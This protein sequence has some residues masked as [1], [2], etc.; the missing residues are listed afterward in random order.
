MKKALIIDDHFVVRIG[1]QFVLEGLFPHI[2]VLEAES[3]PDG[4]QI[5]K[6]HKIDIVILD[7]NI[8]GGE[9]TKMISQIKNTL[10]NCK[11]LIFSD[12][13]EDKYALRYLQA[14]ANGFLSKKSTHKEYLD[15]ISTI[16]NGDKFVSY[17]IQQNILTHIYNRRPT[18][19]I[20]SWK[21]LSSRETEITKLLIQGMWTK[22]IAYKLKLKESTISTFK[23][24]IFDKIGVSNTLELAKKLESELD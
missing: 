3:F 7:I 23:R 24:K 19:Q 4:I 10:P 20:S 13:P 1:T 21:G 16:K 9:D 5:I 18:A 11:V 6:E 8:P 17:H 2:D 14:G 15:A 22:Q 12:L